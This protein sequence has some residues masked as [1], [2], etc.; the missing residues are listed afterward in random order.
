MRRLIRYANFR[1]D[2]E[3]AGLVYKGMPYA[4][5]PSG[6]WGTTLSADLCNKASLMLKNSRKMDNIVF[7]ACGRADRTLE[8][9]SELSVILCEQ[10]SRALVYHLQR[11]GNEWQNL[12]KGYQGEK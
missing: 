6:V 5:N 11:S 2:D 12:A 8:G 3:Q 10:F 7:C 9:V 4:I 1:L